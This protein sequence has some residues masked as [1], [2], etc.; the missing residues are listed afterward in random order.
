MAHAGAMW[1]HALAALLGSTIFHV[2]PLFGPESSMVRAMWCWNAE[3]LSEHFPGNEEN[4]K[5][6]ECCPINGEQFWCYQKGECVNGVWG[7]FQ[8]YIKD[9]INRSADVKVNPRPCAKADGC[10]KVCTTTSTTPFPTMPPEEKG[11][12]RRRS[13]EEKGRRRRR[14]EEKDRRRRRSKSR[15]RR[16]SKEE[17]DDSRRRRR[18]S[19]RR[20]K[21]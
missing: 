4:E 5:N 17:K 6:E 1:K 20:R 2:A 10:D 9:V 12:R 3:K 19:S 7:G 18:R 21:D 16:R 13:D 14:S 15:R 11:R 8:D